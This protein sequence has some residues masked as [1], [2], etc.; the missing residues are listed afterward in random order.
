MQFREH[1]AGKKS[2]FHL[3]RQEFRQVRGRCDKTAGRCEPLP[4]RML[5]LS[6]RATAAVASRK[7]K[8]VVNVDRSSVQ[9]EGIAHHLLQKSVERFAGGTLQRMPQQPKSEI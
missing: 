5:S 8:L 6:S 4:I 1:F 2:R 7:A 3:R 9:L